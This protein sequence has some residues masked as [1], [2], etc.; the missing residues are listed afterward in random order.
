MPWPA[1]SSPIYHARDDHIIV[2]LGDIRRAMPA[3]GCSQS[4]IRAVLERLEPIE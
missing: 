3:L 2:T 1:N 4:D